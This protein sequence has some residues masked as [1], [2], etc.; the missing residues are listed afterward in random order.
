MHER[1]PVEGIDNLLHAKTH[2]EVI[3]KFGRF[4]TRNMALN[5]TNTTLEA[6]FMQSGGYGMTYTQLANNAQA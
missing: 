4:P 5:R 2:R 3:R 1:M 6:D